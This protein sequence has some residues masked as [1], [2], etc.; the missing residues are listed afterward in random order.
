MNKNNVS[1]KI[2]IITPML[3]GRGGT[4][5]VLNTVLSN[6]NYLKSVKQIDLIIL[7]NKRENEWT[8]T[9]FSCVKVHFSTDIKI[10]RLLNLFRLLIL[11]RYTKVICLSTTIL[12]V[13]SKFRSVTKKKF[14]IFSWIHF[15]L[16][17]EK[18]VNVSYLK[19]A[20]FNLAISSGIAEELR[21][22]GI[23]YKKIKII[24]NPVS[25]KDK[26]ISWSKDNHLKLIYVGRVLLNGQKNL[27]ELF[28]A[29]NLVK[30]YSID[31]EVYGDGEI[32]ICKDYITNINLHQNIYWHGWMND[33]WNSI[34]SADALVLTSKYEGFPMTLLE[35]ISYGV[36]IISANCPTGPNDL[37]KN[38]NGYLYKMGDVRGLAEIISSFD[39]K[40]FNRKIIKDTS[41]QFYTNT[42]LKRFWNYIFEN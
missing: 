25:P 15:S 8:D 17:D 41:K 37:V 9:L 40:T 23:P 21:A 18:T 4:E 22:I 42:F 6:G 32:N 1:E 10:I 7:G 29:L 31:L 33:P 12:N 30:K 34:K 38:D 16:F 24:Y 26:V 11:N 35:S 13:V 20:D 39:K 28:D 27:K 14:T 19:L 36:P 3:S 5:T 2:A